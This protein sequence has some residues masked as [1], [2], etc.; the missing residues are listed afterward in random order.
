MAQQTSPFI[1]G[2]FGWGLGESGWNYGMDEN[3]LKFS[4]LF[5]KNV[6]GIVSSLPAAVNGN[7]YFL[8]TDNRIYYAVN[9]IYYST[10]IPKWFEFTL[11]TTGAKYQFDGT[12]PVIIDSP[13]EIDSRLD[14]VDTSIVNINSD[15][16]TINSNITTTNTNL[17]NY[18]NDVANASDSLKGA[19]L[20]GYSG[21]TVA[22]KFTSLD[23][24][25]ALKADT[26]ALT[27]GLATKANNAFQRSET[28]AVASTVSDK[29]KKIIHIEDFG[30]AGDGVTDNST[31]LVNAIAAAS[32]SGQSGE[33]WFM[34]GN[35]LFNS[36]VNV[37]G[38]V[39]LRGN[40]KNSTRLIRNFTAGSD[41]VGLLNYNGYTASVCNMAMQ[42]A[43]GVTGGCLISLVASATAASPDFSLFDNL[44]LTYGAI[45]TYANCV[46]INGSARTDNIGV[47]DV[48][49][50]DCDMFGGTTGTVYADTTVNLRLH[51]SFFKGGSTSGKITIT[52]TGTN[53]SYYT[54]IDGNDL[55]GLSLNKCIY[56]DVR[57]TVCVTQVT[58][59]S[60]AR[61]FNLRGVFNASWQNNWNNCKVDDPTGARTTRAAKSS[62]TDP[63][64]TIH[65]YDTISLTTSWQSF[66]FSKSYT[67][68]AAVLS[69]TGNAVAGSQAS[70]Y[71]QNVTAS[72]FEATANASCTA[73][74]KAEGW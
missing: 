73:K 66:T 33:V 10:P 22:S 13:A 34:N 25:L 3:L 63:D 65:N 11:K 50:R 57:C 53:D 37:L 39:T 47:R 48:T 4:Y 26:T 16:T 42:T 60:T 40:G 15:I 8:T 2:K 32:A 9:G 28:G 58:N 41:S 62:K 30:G 72:G 64:G 74:I 17:Q 59:T 12:T 14:G 24:A 67:S 6:N 51:G 49:F 31:P 20:V 70:V 18:K 68:A 71:F 44:Y 29:L 23:S 69:L 7:A 55:D 45:N 5:D 52:G 54:Y 43:S 27:S 19:A 21:G 46:Y 36:A 56:G 1:E 35:Y 61:Y 38:K